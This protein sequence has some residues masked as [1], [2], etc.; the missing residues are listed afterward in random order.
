MSGQLYIENRGFFE[1]L[2]KV[3][4]RKDYSQRIYNGNPFDYSQITGVEAPLKQDEEVRVFD[5]NNQFV[6]IY[7]Y[8]RKNKE[9]RNVKMF[10]GVRDLFSQ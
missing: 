3:V 7:K 10:F 9:F 4:V 8:D 6:G 1:G 5:E 2:Q